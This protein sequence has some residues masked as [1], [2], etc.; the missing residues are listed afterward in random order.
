MGLINILIIFF[1][2]LLTYQVILAFSTTNTLIEGLENEGTTNS[3]TQEYKP[4]NLND[5]NNSL[6]LS[7]QNAGNIEVLRGRI[8]KFDGVKEQVDT[9]QQ[10]IDSMQVQMDALVQQQAD[11]AQ[12]IA[13]STPPYITGT[14]AETT[15]NVEASI[16]EEENPK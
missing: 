7:Q 10:E 12:E 1:I 9:M 3:S 8:D 13:G 11:Y 15:E 14:D 2:I 5:P 16:E 4:Y 6:I